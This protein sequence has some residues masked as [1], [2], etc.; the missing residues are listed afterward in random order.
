MTRNF[1]VNEYFRKQGL[2][3]RP[4]FRFAGHSKDD[5]RAWRAALLPAL[6]ASLG[7]MPSRV[8]LNP[9]IVSETREDGLVKQRVVFDVEEG[10]SV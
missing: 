4:T 2:Q 3:H 8:P 7:R 1:S 9:E 6:K 5:W 10:L